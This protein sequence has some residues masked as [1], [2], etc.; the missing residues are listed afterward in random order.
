MTNPPD[1]YW[2]VYLDCDVQFRIDDTA[3]ETLR[4]DIV[5]GVV[6]Y[7][8]IWD[9]AREPMLVPVRKVALLFRSTPAS[10]QV[11]RLVGEQL[12]AE[13]GFES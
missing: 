5:T 12:K 1:E 4:R 13:Q 2:V 7:A 3:A 9:M 11:D 8:E 10:R 6:E